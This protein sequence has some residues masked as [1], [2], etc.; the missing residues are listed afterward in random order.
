MIIIKMK[1]KNLP[2]S[3]SKC[4]AWKTCE[5]VMQALKENDEGVWLPTNYRHDACPME[6]IVEGYWE[7]SSTECGIRCPVCGTTMDDYVGSIDYV[8]LRLYPNYC[9]HCGAR[10]YRKEESKEFFNFPF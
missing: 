1:N 6:E 3:C 4:F 8:Y 2:K 7:D 5:I 9:P 10:L